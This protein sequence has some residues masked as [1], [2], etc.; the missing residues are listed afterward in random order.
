MLMHNTNKLN[1]NSIPISKVKFNY[2]LTTLPTR[3]YI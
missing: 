2:T 1:N 3:P